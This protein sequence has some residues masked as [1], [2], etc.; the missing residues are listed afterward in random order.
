VVSPLS[1]HG[2]LLAPREF[3]AFLFLAYGANNMVTDRCVRACVR[4]PEL[5]MRANIFLQKCLGT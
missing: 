4:V 5:E 1:F 3:S 2:A